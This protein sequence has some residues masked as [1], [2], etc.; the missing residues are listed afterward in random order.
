MLCVELTFPCDFT[1][2]YQH[3]QRRFRPMRGHNCS[4]LQ[5]GQ[6]QLLRQQVYVKCN[7]NASST[8]VIWYWCCCLRHQRKLGW[9]Q[10]LWASPTDLPEADLQAFVTASFSIDAPRLVELRTMAKT[11]LRLFELVFCTQPPQRFPFHVVGPACHC[12]FCLFCDGM[13][14]RV[15]TA[16]NFL[17]D[18]PLSRASLDRPLEA[19]VSASLSHADSQPRCPVLDARLPV[20]MRRAARGVRACVRAGVPAINRTGSQACVRACVRGCY[21]RAPLAHDHLPAERLDFTGQGVSSLHWTQAGRRVSA[22][23]CAGRPGETDTGLLSPTRSARLGSAPFQP[24]TASGRSLL[25]FLVAS[26]PPA[27]MGPPPSPPAAA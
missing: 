1:W 12:L 13:R 18:P 15:R 20:S 19:N 2:S 5:P 6:K 25:A 10:M 17:V 3:P 23:D 11:S 24:S 26:P 27:Q 22:C 8:H 7:G 4:P 9:Q 21:P 16:S 14:R